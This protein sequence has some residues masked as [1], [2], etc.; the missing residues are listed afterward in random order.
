MNGRWD[1]DVLVTDLDG[2]ALSPDKQ[3]S[4]GVKREIARLLSSGVMVVIAT[5]RPRL[6]TDPVARELRLDTPMITENGAVVTLPGAVE[7]ISRVAIPPEAVAEILAV[8]ATVDSHLISISTPTLLALSGDPAYLP[9]AV[10]TDELPEGAALVDLERDLPP[11]PVTKVWVCADVPNADLLEHRLS[12]STVYTPVRSMPET[13]DI[14]AEGVTKLSALQAL[15]DSWGIQKARVMAI[16]DGI[17]DIE[18]LSGVGFSVAMGHA[19]REV[20]E[21]ANAV[22]LTNA[23]DGLAVAIRRWFPTP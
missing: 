22:T 11:G 17:N 21:A 13:L 15:M 8:L 10:G 4:A 2:T 6:A 7:P 5:G 14:T 12:G 16:G 9:R 20:R 19:P 1:F 23:E 18:L 3:A